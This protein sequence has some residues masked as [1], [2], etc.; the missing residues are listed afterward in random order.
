[1]ESLWRKD[2]EMPS[3]STLEG[4]VKTDV[5]IIGGGIA[6]ILTAH[7]LHLIQLSLTLIM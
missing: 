5:L 1:M 2:V 6:G 3:F 4:D 7:F